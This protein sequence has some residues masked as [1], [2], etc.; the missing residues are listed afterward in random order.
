VKH[1]C[2]YLGD[3]K[4]TCK[5]TPIQIERYMARLSGPLL[6]WIDLQRGHVI[7][8]INYRTLDRKLWAR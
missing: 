8:A 2:G 5:C 6:D 1:P 3:A 4:H 7:E